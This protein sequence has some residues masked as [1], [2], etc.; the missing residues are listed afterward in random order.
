MK[1]INLTHAIARRPFFEDK[2]KRVGLFT[3]LVLSN[4]FWIAVSAT[5]LL[6]VISMSKVG[7]SFA[8]SYWEQHQRMAEI[9]D[10]KAQ[11]I[12]E[13][14]LKIANLLSVQNSSTADILTMAKTLNSVFE[15]AQNSAQERFLEAALPEALRIQ[16]TEG[17]P[18]SAVMAQA[19]L[20]SRYGQSS[21]ATKGNNF[22]GIKAFDT[23]KGPRQK[24]VPTLDDGSI[25]TIADFR[26][27]ANLA[28]GFSGY[29]AFL[30]ETGRYDNAFNKKT[31]L[32]FISTVL[33]D[34]YCGD[35]HYVEMV[36]TIINR[37]NL[38]KLDTMYSSQVAKA[39]AAITAK[40]SRS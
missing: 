20:E 9:E 26:A 28:E 4:A 23:W 30:R 17:I 7:K 16:I 34:G 19:I 40:N 18:A 13:R 22:F 10:A 15:T 1:S 8:A 38:D 36:R 31:G 37:H 2:P 3:T 32:E 27:Y 24:N 14:D 11:A 5:L 12:A 25:P 33:R 35:P 21:L 29:A 39:N 6:T